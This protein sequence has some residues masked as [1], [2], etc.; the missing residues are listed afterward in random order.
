MQDLSVKGYYDEIDR[1]DYISTELMVKIGLEWFLST[2]LFKGDV[3][4]VLYSKED[5]VFRRRT[6]T[7]GQGFVK[8][9]NNI[10]NVSLNLPFACYSAAGSYEEDD[11]VA[12]MNT[13][14]AVKGW[15]S[16]ET[17]IVVK[18]MPVKV[19]Y[20][21][22]AFFAK[23]RDVDKAATMLYWEQYP[24]APLYI[25]VEN[26]VA[27]MK[28]DVPVNVTIESIDQNPDYA[29]KDWLTDSKIF[30]VK[31]G[32][33]IRSYQILIEDVENT[34]KLPI[35]FSGLYAY[36]DEDI[37]FTQKTAL[38]WANEKWT[39]HIKSKIN[40]RK[41]EAKELVP[42]RKNT[43]QL[44]SS[45][46]KTAIYT[47]NQGKEVLL[48]NNGK[49]IKEKIDDVIADTVEGYFNQD[50][51]CELDELKQSDQTEN[52]VT[53]SWLIKESQITNF[54]SLT[55]YIPGV[56]SQ[57]IYDCGINELKIEGL[58]PGS[59]YEC[60]VICYSNNDTK[61]TYNLKLK[62]AGKPIIPEGGSGMLSD[63]LI[64]FTFQ[65]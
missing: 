23:L 42:V 54:A 45:E 39:P 27:G 48:N 28:V 18:A 65:R 60:T 8:G 64:G 34:I 4:R 25:S 21:A 53:I 24:K 7:V 15:I 57:G 55:V 59:T 26:D 22:T 10:N 16:P 47:D 3:S 29:E 20:Q 58:N 1:K 6:E 40:L 11:R 31:I 35:R 63:K 36:N 14:A 41:M 17:G 37:V 49:I 9:T 50:R 30:P 51:Q 52:S 32:L 62:T 43:I 19:N 38:I 44:D 12:S 33:T 13:A 61:L 5:I 56:C 2:L 46:E